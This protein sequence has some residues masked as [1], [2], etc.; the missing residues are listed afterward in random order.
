MPL[1]ITFNCFLTESFLEAPST[2]VVQAFFKRGNAS[3][4]D[5]FMGI[6]VG[7][8]L[9]KLFIMILDERLSKCVEQHGLRAKDQTKFCKDYHTTYQLFIL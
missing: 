2:W 8:I 9:A 3:E 5:N 1:L 4:F 7:P 6:I